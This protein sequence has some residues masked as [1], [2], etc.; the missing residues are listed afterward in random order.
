M[1]AWGLL[2]GVLLTTHLA[3]TGRLAEPEPGPDGVVPHYRKLVTGRFVAASVVLMVCCLVL[4]ARTPSDSTAMWVVLG[5]STLALVA[6]D[7]RTTYLPKVLTWWCWGEMVAAL[8]AGWLISP[9]PALVLRV[10]LCSGAA[11]A[12]FWLAWRLGAGLGFGDVRLIGLIVAPA[13]AISV[14]LAWASLLFG[15]LVGVA[16]GLATICWRRRRPSPL[17]AAFAYGPALWLGP[18]FALLGHLTVA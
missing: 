2:A 5:S 16:V 7:L 8:L 6:V 11:T 17:G 3:A 13:A 10:S 12:L 4:A 15:S 9:S 1:M 18:W 14:E